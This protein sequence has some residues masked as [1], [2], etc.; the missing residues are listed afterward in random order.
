MKSSNTQLIE[1][2]REMESA[3]EVLLREIYERHNV[4][5]E[6]AQEYLA[7][8]I[9]R[10]G[11]NTFATML[12]GGDGVDYDEVVADV[13]QA[14]GISLNEGDDLLQLER[15]II[16]KL[17]EDTF[18]DGDDLAPLSVALDKTIGDIQSS[19]ALAEAIRAASYVAIR[20][21]C[22]VIAAKQ[23]VKQVGRT[24]TLAIPFLNIL[25]A[26]WLMIDFA[27]PAFRKTIPTI[28]EIAFFRIDQQS[29][30]GE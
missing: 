17:V 27:G 15:S 5:W 18:N 26:G 22:L 30:M 6:Y 8:E 3:N 7:E 1:L 24:V 4:D 16:L 12:R 29:D 11:S 2:L 21:V 19:Q 13:A 23:G 9:R 20:E 28:I 10:D 25:F 14:I